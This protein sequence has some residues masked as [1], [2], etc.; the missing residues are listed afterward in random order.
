MLISGYVGA[1][2]RFLFSKI[3]PLVLAS[4]F[5]SLLE[6][7]SAIF[8]FKRATFSKWELFYAFFPLAKQRY[9]YNTPFL[10]WLFLSSFVYPSFEKITSRYYFVTCIVVLLMYCLPMA[11]Y[12]TF[13]SLHRQMSIGPFMCMGIIG[14]YVR[15][16]YKGIGN[17]KL[18]ILYILLFYYNFLV[19][20]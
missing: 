8:F 17:G 2:S 6:H 7:F 15:L 5:Y 11:G 1:K 4:S 10:A 16:Y 19:H 3:I 20:Q 12:Y 9:W 14:S 18:I 13:T